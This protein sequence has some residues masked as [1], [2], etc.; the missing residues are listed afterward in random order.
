MESSVEKTLEEHLRWL[1]QS[2]KV[3]VVATLGK[4]R[5]KEGMEKDNTSRGA[6]AFA[7]DHCGWGTSRREQA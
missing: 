7:P 4:E 2:L 5:S 3:R 6:K 1:E